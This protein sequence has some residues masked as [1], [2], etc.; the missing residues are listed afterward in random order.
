[1]TEQR[2]QSLATRLSQ[3]LR[4]H[5]SLEK[6]VAE[7]E[8][9][10][11]E[12]VKS[13]MEQAA[14]SPEDIAALRK[15]NPQTRLTVFEERAC[16]DCGGVHLRSC[17]RVKRRGADGVEYFERWDDSNVIWPEMLGTVDDGADQ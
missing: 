1:M 10:L 3:L 5:R 16:P 13:V 2:G 14:L 11:Q 9:R 8:R 7:L 6:R 12:P 15:V 4:A 17:P